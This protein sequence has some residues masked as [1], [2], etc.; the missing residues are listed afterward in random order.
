MTEDVTVVIAVGVVEKNCP[1]VFVDD[2]LPNL[3]F[4]IQ[5]TNDDPNNHNE[6]KSSHNPPV[7]KSF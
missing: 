3:P 2:P 1:P 5:S 7:C 4:F 6:H